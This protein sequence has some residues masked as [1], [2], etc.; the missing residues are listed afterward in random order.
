MDFARYLMQKFL[1]GM[2]TSEGRI[3]VKQNFRLE[4]VALE[5]KKLINLTHCRLTA[6]I[7]H[8]SLSTSV[9]L[10]ADLCIDLS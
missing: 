4:L 6:R 1:S 7:K 3:F 2:A 10:G 8:A 9:A 5:L